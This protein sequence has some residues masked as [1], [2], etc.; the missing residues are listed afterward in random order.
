MPIQ[1]KSRVISIAALFAF[2]LLNSITAVQTKK[3]S[4]GLNLYSLFKFLIFTF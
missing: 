4:K 3:A 1:N 2:L